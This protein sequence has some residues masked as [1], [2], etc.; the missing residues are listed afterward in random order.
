MLPFS[1]KFSQ[2]LQLA[3]PLF[4]LLVTAIKP[5]NII[6]YKCKIDLEAAQRDKGFVDRFP[7]L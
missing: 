7:T 5:I 3:Y 2:V 1:G 4:T 6:R